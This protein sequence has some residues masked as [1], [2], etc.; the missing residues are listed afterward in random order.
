MAN[1]SSTHFLV[2]QYLIL[3]SLYLL[4]CLLTFFLYCITSASVYA[5]ITQRIFWKENIYFIES[6]VLLS[7][8]DLNPGCFFHLVTLTEWLSINYLQVLPFFAFIVMPC[9]FSAQL[10]RIL[11][12]IIEDFWAPA[13]S[14]SWAAISCMQV[15]ERVNNAISLFWLLFQAI[16]HHTMKYQWA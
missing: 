11:S 6:F 5:Y 16:Q 9:C 14:H 10:N 1:C 4:H 3:P 13:S 7:V 15:W 8:A 12:Y 2:S